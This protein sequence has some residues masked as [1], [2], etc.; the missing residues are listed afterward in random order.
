M[1]EQ[2]WLL[3]HPEQFEF[4]MPKRSSS[5]IPSVHIR[6]GPTTILCNRHVVTPRWL[7]VGPPERPAM[8][9]VFCA[10]LASTRPPGAGGEGA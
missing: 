8:L 7:S 1:R 2:I 4:V 6:T 3:E 9:C 10:R 5:H